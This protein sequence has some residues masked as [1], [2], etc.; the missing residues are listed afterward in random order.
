MDETTQSSAA[1]KISTVLAG[2][3]PEH[4]ALNQKVDELERLAIQGDAEAVVKMLCEMVPTF[5]PMGS[6]TPLPLPKTQ[7]GTKLPHSLPVTLY[8]T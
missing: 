3:L 2:W 1:E 8:Q 4:G 7:N 5:R 6:L